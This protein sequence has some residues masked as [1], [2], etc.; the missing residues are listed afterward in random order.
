MSGVIVTI[1]L[2]DAQGKQVELQAPSDAPAV[3]IGI[4][5]IGC[6]VFDR[7]EERHPLTFARIY[8]QRIAPAPEIPT[9]DELRL[10]DGVSN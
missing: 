7:T 9:G 4:G 6:F 2:Q 8:Q 5:P 3:M 1:C 10:L